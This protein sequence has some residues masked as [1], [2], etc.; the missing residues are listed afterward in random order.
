MEQITITITDSGEKM[1]FAPFLELTIGRSKM[2]GM[3]IKQPHVSR[4]HGRLRN[5]G[6][7]YYYQDINSR[8]GSYLGLQQIHSLQLAKQDTIFLSESSIKIEISLPYTPIK[9]LKFNNSAFK[10]RDIM[11]YRHIKSWTVGRGT[12]HFVHLPFSSVSRE[13]TEFIWDKENNSFFLRDLGSENGTFVNGSR[14]YDR[15]P[16]FFG[17]EIKIGVVE[18]LFQ[19][20]GENILCEQQ[21]RVKSP[22]VKPGKKP[23]K[24]DR[25][26]IVLPTN[27]KKPK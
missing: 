11:V 5:I 7:L 23:L 17:D 12:G 25:T 4:F 22:R 6:G 3:Q 14:Q 1:V 21:K 19:F 15:T 18:F 27:N 9:F 2:A 13:H 10:G 8:N 26:T 20:S 24:E 16:L